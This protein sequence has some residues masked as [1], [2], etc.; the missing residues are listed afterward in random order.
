MES[1]RA[2]TIFVIP[3]N[4]SFEVINFVVPEPCIFIWIPALIAEVAAVIPNVAKTFFAKG[5]ATLINGLANLVNNDPKNLL[6]WI[7]L[8]IWASEIL[9]QLIYCY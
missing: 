7:I 8:E 5:I 4:S 1:S 2:W 3:F 6:D 9:N